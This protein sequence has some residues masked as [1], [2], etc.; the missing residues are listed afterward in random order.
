M[1][2]CTAAEHTARDELLRDVTL[3][4]AGN[5]VLGDDVA[6][7]LEHNDGLV[8]A[9]LAEVVGA[10]VAQDLLCV[11]AVG[12]GVV[13]ELHAVHHRED[14][15]S[16][17]AHAGQGLVVAVV[18]GVELIA[19]EADLGSPVASHLVDGGLEQLV[20][21]LGLGEVLDA[22]GTVAEVGSAQDLPVGGDH[23][24]PAG[25]AQDAQVAG[26]VGA[27]PDG[28]QGLVL[29]VGD[30][31][32]GHDG[33]HLA[34]LGLEVKAAVQER[35]QVGVEVVARE[36]VVLARVVVVVAAALHG[37]GAHIVLEHDSD[38]VLAPALIVGG[39]VIAPG[40]LHTAA[41]G[42]AQVAVGRG[43]LADRAAQ[44][45]PHDIRAD[46]DLGPEVHAGAAG[47]PGA[48]GVAAGLLPKLRVEAGNQAV[49][50][51][52]VVELV[53]IGRVHVRDA[54]GV[55][56]LAPLLDG[57]NPRDGSGVVVRIGVCA[58]DAC[59]HTFLEGGHGVVVERRRGA[60]EAVVPHERDDLLGGELVCQGLCTDVD[61]LAPVLVE[62]ELA[63]AVR[64]AEGIAVDLDDLG[65]L[66]DTEL[67][68]R[69]LVGHANP[70]VA[71]GLGGPLGGDAV[72]IGVDRVLVG[73][74]RGQRVFPGAALGPAARERRGKARRQRRARQEAPARDVA[75]VLLLL[76]VE[77]G[78]AR[79]SSWFCE[80][81]H[82]LALLRHS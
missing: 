60:H 14:S 20:E 52:D 13:E 11:L 68:A 64:V 57:V 79:P 21:A 12:V 63:V 61:R 53:G 42:L 1:R 19:L 67:G 78:R 28:A 35:D 59:A 44:A 8:G 72:L 27:A 45:G 70:T 51:G 30:A 24:V 32:V 66:H 16:G 38:G 10:L 58:R 81:P 37:A 25:V 56:L 69:V 22:V 77:W 23:A 36:D 73:S 76:L 9:L 39:V 71:R 34:G 55:V 65:L 48:T 6:G 15:A 46:V 62:V 29:G 26:I 54:V 41:E 75:H 74:G 43:V 17:V 82:A 4:L 18:L 2:G 3:G 5:A 7:V 49:V 40:G 33:R 31:V 80:A 47:A 50:V